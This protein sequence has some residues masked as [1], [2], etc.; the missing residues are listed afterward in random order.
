MNARTKD[1][2]PAATA[3]FETELK[4]QVPTAARAALL[5][6]VATTTA[7]R[8]RL[9]ATYADTADHRLAAAGFAL[10]MRLE[11]P[12]WVQTLKGRGDGLAQRLEDEVPIGASRQEPALDAARHAGTPAGAAL[13]ALLADGAAL[14]PLYRTDIQRLHRK[15][16]HAGAV[17]ELAYD[18]G[19]IEAGSE[20]IAVDEI[21]FELVSGPPQAL[22][23]LAARWAAR[24]GLWWDVRTKSERGF[25]LATGASQVPAVRADDAV[26]PEG[27]GVFS[28]WQSTLASALAQ[29]LPNAAEVAAGSGTSE[30]LHQLRVAIRRLRS[31][32]SLLAAWGIEQASHD[33]EAR[34][35]ICFAELG[36]A[37][38]ADVI[39]QTWLPRL[40]AAGCPSLAMPAVDGAAVPAEVVCGPVFTAAALETLALV[41]APMPE[42]VDHSPRRAAASQVLRRAWRRAWSDG[43]VFEQADTPHRHRARK[44]IKR[45]RYAFEF[46]APLYPAKAARPVRKA[47]NGALEAL[48]HCNDLQVAREHFSAPGSSP[49]AQPGAWFAD[50]WLAAQ[51]PAALRQALKALARLKAASKPW[52]DRSRR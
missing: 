2:A 8:T 29:A 47:L 48:G 51:Q 32:L 14:V 12:V 27:D 15:V 5:R 21:E 37:R 28:V 11:G 9:R 23:Q 45:L 24:H 42:G 44:R 20:R 43:S 49:A 18:R 6:A 1:H 33:V 31:A 22:P 38:D 52:R 19:F 46:L 10:R 34:W 35:A 39:G 13:A 36:Q 50:G 40:Q 3:R 41:L 7:Q 25:R 17:V 30:H 26:M 16:R 4:F